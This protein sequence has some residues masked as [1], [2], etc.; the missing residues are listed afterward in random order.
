MLVSLCS[1]PGINSK[2]KDDIRRLNSKCSNIVE[3]RL[4][5]NTVTMPK[6]VELSFIFDSSFHIVSI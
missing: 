5:L 3:K 6:L 2:L 1:L 4:S